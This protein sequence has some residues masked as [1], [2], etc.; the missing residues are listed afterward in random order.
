MLARAGYGAGAHV[1]IGDYSSRSSA[2]FTDCYFENNVARKSA[3]PVETQAWSRYPMVLTCELLPC[4]C[5]AD[6]GGLNVGFGR[7]SLF[8]SST[9]V[10]NC[11]FINNTAH[12]TCRTWCTVSASA[13]VWCPW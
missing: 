2:T 4:V 6:G 12:G 13:C 11:V 1:L 3:Q 10:Q 9:L 8:N 5:I 7:R